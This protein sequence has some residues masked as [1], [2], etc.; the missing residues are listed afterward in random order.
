MQRRCSSQS[1]RYCGVRTSRSPPI[2][3]RIS[4]TAFIASSMGRGAGECNE[5]SFALALAS[6]CQYSQSCLDA[7][8][9]PS[10]LDCFTRMPVGNIR[11]LPAIRQQA[12]RRVFFTLRT[13]RGT[14]AGNVRRIARAPLPGTRAAAGPTAERSPPLAH[15][16]EQGLEVL[17]LERAEGPPERRGAPLVV[18]EN[19]PRQR[20]W[21][22]ADGKRKPR[23]ARHREELRAYGQGA[24]NNPSVGLVTPETDKD[25]VRKTCQHDP[26]GAVGLDQV[27]WEPCLRS[28][29]V[30]NSSSSRILL[31]ANSLSSVAAPCVPWTSHTITASC[32]A[33]STLLQRLGSN[34]CL[35]TGGPCVSLGPWPPNERCPAPS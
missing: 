34:R 19:H 22:R 5:G 9:T 1:P 23:Q 20:R 33:A 4:L 32:W 27:V 12:E 29:A 6:R 18:G 28:T 25:A 15:G 21:K 17:P 13:R 10:I 8:A 24:A 16:S 3:W 11:S 31:S 30:K 7:T 35:P 26:H 2:L 14:R